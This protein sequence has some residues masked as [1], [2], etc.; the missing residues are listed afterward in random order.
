MPDTIVNYRERPLAPRERPCLLFVHG[1]TGSPESTWAPLAAVMREL[2]ALA[3]WDLAGFR[4]STRPRIDFRGLWSG[5]ARLD[6]IATM[7]RSETETGA[8]AGVRVLALVAHSMGGLVCQRVVA[9]SQSIRQALSSLICF[10]T[11]SNGLVKAGWGSPFK[12]QLEDMAAN[13]PFV[14]GL[15]SDWDQ[16]FDGQP[17]F[18]FRLVAG[19]KDQF[20]PPQASIDGFPDD[21]KA[22]IPGNHVTMINPVRTGKR[23]IEEV[24]GIVLDEARPSAVFDSAHL[25]LERGEFQKVADQLLPGAADLDNSARVALA[26]ALTGLGRLDEALE[27]A[28]KEETDD[29]DLLGVVG[30]RLKRLWLARRAQSVGTEALSTYRRA[31]A[32]AA[33]RQDHGQAHYNGINVAFLECLLLRDKKAARDTAG[34]TLEHCTNQRSEGLADLWTTASEAEA[35]LYLGE[36]DRAM[37]RYTAFVAESP[38][39][40]QVSSAYDQ[41]GYVATEL[42]DS[43]QQQRLHA[44]FEAQTVTG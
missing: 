34:K 22:V 43:E 27:V 36:I 7:L 5:D 29:T 39:P 14:T 38:E 32:I 37:E 28:S 15:R 6:E 24:C 26:I 30:G 9:S 35:H 17:P 10:G 12:G 16:L 41:A 19:E 18:R 13:S 8:L 21:Q 20:V 42:L 3:G 31:F 1:F 2:P 33:N 25:A 4:Y 44:S 23:A 40:W 11:P